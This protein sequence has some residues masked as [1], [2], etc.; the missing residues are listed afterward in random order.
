MSGGKVSAY[1][2]WWTA[3]LTLLT[4]ITAVAFWKTSLGAA[5]EASEL[6]GVWIADLGSILVTGIAA[7][8]VLR[9]A[10]GFSK[11]E[12]FRK[13]WLLIG[14]G[15]ACY[16]LGDIVWALYELRGLEVP[17]PG[18]PDV[19]YLAE[20]A[21][22]AAG[23][24]IAARAYRGLVDEKVPLIVSV[25]AAAAAA[26]GLWAGL[27]GAIAAD[28]ETA[29]AE[30]AISIAYPTFDVLFG[31]AP[32]LFLLLV[33]GKLGGG[34]LARQWWAV[35]GGLLLLAI[36]DTVYSWMAWNETYV[37]GSAVDYGWMLAATAI[38]MGAL[39]ARDLAR[40]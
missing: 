35:G 29:L 7:I 31:L 14:I 25:A 26:A 22:L 9:T 10:L 30:R 34:R 21:F 19:F 3:A 37:S 8:I 23:L 40:A 16:A 6:A 17:Y 13:Y 39:L 12:P 11:G 38:A 27:L 4:A 2:A 5:G 33:V 24:V 32:A 1:T 36:S 20:Y 15:A 28:T 18:A